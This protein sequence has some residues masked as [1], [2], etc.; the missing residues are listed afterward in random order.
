MPHSP[1]RRRTTVV[2]VTLALAAA[3]VLSQPA[4][5]DVPFELGPGFGLL[6]V[7]VLLALFF[8]FLCSVAE[9]VLLSITP[10]YIAELRK[11]DPKQADRLQALKGEGIDRSLAAILTVN[12]I[13]HTV[14]AIGAGAK[15]T[16]VFG[17]AWFGVFSAV[18][19][20]LILFLSEIVPKTIG[21]VHW[22]RLSGFTATYV[23]LLIKLT[24]PLIVVSELLTRMI[25]RG[26]KVH[27]FSRDEFV[28]MADIGQKSGQIDAR[29][30]KIIRNLFRF[31]ALTAE[32]I[33]TPRT[34]MTALQADTTI[35]QAYEGGGRIPYSRLPLY[36]KDKDDS[37]GFV[38]REDI[39]VAH[40]QG[41]DEAPVSTLRRD[42]L[43]VPATS[44]LD[45][46][47]DALLKRRQHIALVVGEFGET[48]GVVTLEDLVETLI[49]E[50]IMD[51]GDRIA[52]MQV[53]A[54]QLWER[55]ARASG[56]ELP[57]PGSAGPEAKN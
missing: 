12:T 41:R 4:G 47:M 56:V 43:S 27:R 46:L 54:R 32:D 1:R 10:S 20:L 36:G 7:Y 25:A 29:E 2:S 39:L 57:A 21:A 35:G 3:P 53:M 11:R 45:G 33:M 49:G 50:E 26:Q 40:L 13:A 44:N 18:M 38:L 55:R 51:E 23:N 9:A 14:G 30:S 24:Y 19:T 34:V 22:R 52:D 28:A 16:S 6:L 5:I 31:K 15:A 37:I 17:D 42:L 48:R 8:S